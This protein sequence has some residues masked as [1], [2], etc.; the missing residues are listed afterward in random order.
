MGKSRSRRWL[1]LYFGL[2]LAAFGCNSQD[3]ER[4]AKVA[5][6]LGDKLELLAGGADGR[7]PNWQTLR[8]GMEELT[9]EARVSARLRWEQALEGAAI[10]VSVK[11]GN[12]ELKGTV[13]DM[14]QRR[15]AVDL[16]GS[17]VGVVEVVDRLEMAQ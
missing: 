12:V 3:T 4:L 17:T 14:G 5:R 6:H 8:P 10:Q 7:L 16:A 1:P 13:R 9:L 15:R 2:A 11:D